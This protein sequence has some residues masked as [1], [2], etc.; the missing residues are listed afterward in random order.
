MN[1]RRDANRFD[2]YGAGSRGLEEVATELTGSLNVE[3]KLHASDYFGDYLLASNSEERIKIQPN[4]ADSEGYLLEAEHVSH[5]MLIYVD[6][7][8]RSPAIENIMR[9]HGFTLLRSTEQ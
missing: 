4:L 2:V 5:R 1:E 7:S 9:Q 3:F 6:R 8:N